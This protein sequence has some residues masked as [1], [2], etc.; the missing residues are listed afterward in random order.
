VNAGMFVQFCMPSV[1]VL[2]GSVVDCA[3]M[4]DFKRARADDSARISR[5]TDVEQQVAEA[6]RMVQ[7]SVGG[8]LAY[9]VRRL[10]EGAPEKK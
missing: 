5:E 3:P 10:I 2:A 4:A 7:T 6:L 9:R 1:A 8:A